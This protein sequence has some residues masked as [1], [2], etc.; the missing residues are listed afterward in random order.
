MA[1]YVLAVYESE[2]GMDV[3][4]Y[5][6][7]EDAYSAIVEDLEEWYEDIFEIPSFEAM[8]TFSNNEWE[9]NGYGA[10]IVV[11]D[12]YIEGFFPYDDSVTCF[13]IEEVK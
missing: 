12:N 9:E 2:E 7:I 11:K 6:N 5:S 3:H 10:Y 13:I 8:H 1:T 4:T